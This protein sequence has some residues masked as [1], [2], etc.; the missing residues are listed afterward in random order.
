AG[1]DGEIEVVQYRIGRGVSERHV[2]ETDL[3]PRYVEI[4]GIGRV[5][6]DGRRIEQ[7]EDA[8]GAGARELADG[9]DRGKLTNRRRDEEHVGG[10][11]QERAEGD[12]AIEGQPPA[13]REHAAL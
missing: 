6:H 3:G 8:L 12:A 4:R 9:E 5:L 1:R 11:R 2:L 13:E 7:V 10:E